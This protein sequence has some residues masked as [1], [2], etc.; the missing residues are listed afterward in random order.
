MRKSIIFIIVILIVVG[1]FIW[2]DKPKKTVSNFVKDK[3]TYPDLSIFNFNTNFPKPIIGFK[4]GLLTKDECKE[5]IEIGK[6]RVRKS[7]VGFDYQNNNSRTSSHG[8]LSPND[9][10]AINRVTNYLSHILKIP[11]EN[12]E[13]WQCVNYKIGQEYLYHTDSCNPSADDYVACKENE[14][15]SGYRLYTT[16]IYLNDEYDEGHT[17]FKNIDTK[18]KGSPGSA[19][20]FQNTLD[21]KETNELSLHAGLPPI[22]GEKWL[23]NVWIRDKAYNA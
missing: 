7:A 10:P 16:L 5:I 2:L 14:K 18:V 11:L 17:H 4:E 20:I 22:N 1:C 13:L 6:K 3:V 19:V 8:W 12:F 23:I 15:I 21:N 9:H